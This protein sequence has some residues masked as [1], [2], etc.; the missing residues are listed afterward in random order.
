MAGVGCVMD[1]GLWAGLCFSWGGG[2]IDALVFSPF[3]K[4]PSLVQFSSPC[5][6]VSVASGSL[7]TH[8][9]GLGGLPCTGHGEEAGEGG[10]R[11]SQGLCR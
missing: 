5:A 11:V 10:L 8:F 2:C 6:H 4:V 3:V 9:L 7:N 1:W